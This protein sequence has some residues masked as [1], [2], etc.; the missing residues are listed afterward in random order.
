MSVGIGPHAAHHVVGCGGDGDHLLRD[1]DA[2]FLTR[3]GDH[4][5]HLFHSLDLGGVEP[6]MVGLVLLH[7][8]EDAACDDI[9]GCQL[10]HLVVFRHEALALVVAQ[11]GTGTAHR[12]GEQEIGQSLDGKGRGMELYELHVHHLGTGAVG[13]CHAAARRAL[14]VGRMQEETADAACGEDGGLG[15]QAHQPA[16]VHG[17]GSMA[18]AVT[19][20]QVDDVAVLHGSDVLVFGDDRVQR[21]CHLGAGGV[22]LCVHD[23]VTAVASF[24]SEVQASVGLAVEEGAVVDEV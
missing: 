8:L 19:C 5:E 2:V 14:R 20:Q 10:C 3:V 13:Q 9:A 17:D 24:A 16:V 18:V 21:A 12:F 1:V 23:A 11:H 7:L 4:R 15:T 6:D 22:A